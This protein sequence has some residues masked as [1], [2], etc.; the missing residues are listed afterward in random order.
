[1]EHLPVP[2]Q[3]A[4]HELMQ[5]FRARPPLS[6]PGSIMRIEKSGRGYWVSRRRI[7]DRVVEKTI[8][9]E[10]PEVLATVAAARA[11]CSAP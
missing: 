11:E 2:I 1:M 5:R 8:G 6:V 10:T 9:P 3:A 4:Y 7:G